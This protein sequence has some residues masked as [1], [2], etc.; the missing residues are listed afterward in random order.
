M[1]SLSHLQILN[2]HNKHDDDSMMVSTNLNFETREF[3]IE[4]HDNNISNM[5]MDDEDRNNCAT[6]NS[7]NDMNNHI[8]D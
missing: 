1:T 7:S 6:E 2:E 8:E 4:S 5:G 3:K